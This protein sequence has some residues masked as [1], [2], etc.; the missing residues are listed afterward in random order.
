M[1][2]GGRHNGAMSDAPRSPAPS[3]LAIVGGGPAGLFAAEVA[4]AAGVEVDLFDAKGSV[5]RKFLIAGKGGL[6]LTHAEPRP[7][8]DARYGARAN[9]IG[10][11]LDAFD[12]QALRDWAK[13]R[14]VPTFV[15]S[16]GRVFPEDLKAAPLLRGWVRQLREDGVRFHVQH[17]WTGWDADDR[18][19]FETPQGPQTHAAD[20]V[21]LAMGGGSWPE[22]G[23]DGAWQSLLAARGIEVAPLVPAN[24]GFD[25]GW[26][27]HLAQRHAGA[28]LKPVIL[29]WRAAD[30]TPQALQG[31]CVLTTTGIEGSA[32]YAISSALRDTIVRDGHARLEIDLA[33]GR[34]AARLQRDL[35]RPRGRRSIGEHLRRAT[36]LDAAKTA[37]L[38][39]RLD[40]DALGDAARVAAAIKRLPLILRAPR[41]LA[42]AISSAGGVRFEALDEALMLRALPGTFVA[43]EM[44][45]WE[46]PTGG[47]LLTACFASGRRAAQGALDWLQRTR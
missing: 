43:G 32:I 21:L 11:W 37:L 41:P 27:A 16:S 40:R 45:D 26:S 14:G 35:E 47:Y 13:A 24:C 44:I 36:G 30:G 1:S 31:E 15:G 5:G 6:N 10:R 17:R 12:A 46:A 7:A 34:D 18:L 3:R 8:F 23:S 39:E 33:P 4:R 25:I 29:H 9:A 28:P 19:L 2:A 22:L 42:E 20:A 38:F